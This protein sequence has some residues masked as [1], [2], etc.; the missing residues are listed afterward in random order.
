MG[1]SLDTDDRRF[2][3]QFESGDLPPAEFDHRGHIRL[4]YIYLV[5]GDPDT[6]AERMKQ[7]LLE[8]LKRNGVDLS[9][10]HETMTRAWILA[11]KHFMEK[12]GP[13]SSAGAFIDQ[14]PVMLDSKIML[15]HYSAEL[16][17]SDEARGRFVEPNIED[18]PR[19]GSEP[20]G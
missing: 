9:K 12:S 11:V 16:L 14:N 8:F 7:G 4:A 20:A 13:A 18:I 3:E 2:L 19:Y 17:F 15:S 5:E 1:H 10:Y 6:A